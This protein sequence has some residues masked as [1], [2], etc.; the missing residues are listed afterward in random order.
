[1]QIVTEACW[2]RQKSQMLINQLTKGEVC[3]SA[4]TLNRS[5]P[6]AIRTLLVVQQPP[7]WG[8]QET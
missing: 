8:S 1:M 7:M 4:A 2:T 6:S 3:H 5:M